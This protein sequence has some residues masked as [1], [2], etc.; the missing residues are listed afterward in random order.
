[1]AI[2]DTRAQYGFT[3]ADLTI[4]ETGQSLAALDWAAAAPARLTGGGAG[5]ADEIVEWNRPL[6]VAEAAMWHA[7][8]PVERLFG[9]VLDALARTLRRGA[10]RVHVELDLLSLAAAARRPVMPSPPS[11]RSRARRSRRSLNLLA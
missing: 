1:M 3:A 9:G 10:R 6:T 5:A 7:A 4:P 8:G 11:H 2:V